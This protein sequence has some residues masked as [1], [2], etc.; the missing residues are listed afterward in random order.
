MVGGEGWLVEEY[1]F[2]FFGRCLAAGAYV[3]LLLRSATFLWLDEAT[4]ISRFI[5]S[6]IL[7]EIRS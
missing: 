3:I 6:D 2:L 7:S 4:P 1:N 5:L